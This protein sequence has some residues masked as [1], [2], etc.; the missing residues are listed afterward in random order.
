MA[1]ALRSHGVS[2]EFAATDDDGPDVRLA[3]DA[4]ERK[5]PGRHYFA[6]QT[7]LY[8]YAP[9]FTRWLKREVG[10]FDLVHVHGLFSHVD[11]AAGRICRR[12][13]VPYVVTP[14]GMA[15]AY[16]MRHKRFRKQLSFALC[17]RPLLDHAAVVHLTSAGEAADF[18]LLGI[19]AP[20]S[21][22]QLSV[23]GP[24]ARA[25]AGQFSGHFNIP[26][27]RKLVAFVGRLNPI[28]NLESLIDAMA[29]VIASEPEAMLVICGS[30]HEPYRQS[31]VARVQRLGLQERVVWAGHVDAQMKWSMMA[32]AHCFVLPSLSESFG[33]AAVEAAAAGVPCVVSK[34]VAVAADL[35]ELG[36]AVA[37]EHDPDSLAGAIIAVLR[38]GRAP[39]APQR[40]RAHFSRDRMAVGLMD[41]YRRAFGLQHV[42]A[43]S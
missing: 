34:Q 18:Q 37:V 24:D 12:A 14:H 27:G 43:S 9:S 22:V 28:K 7:E 23:D 15:N 39:A 20:V 21:L 32:A 30:G 29:G 11:I 38:G 41:I 4:Q 8:Q 31:L 19:K 17:E 5:L 36:A 26:A 10:R 42:T 33:L 13:G 40:V 3:L 6:K 2:S 1:D 25:N 35:V 16:G